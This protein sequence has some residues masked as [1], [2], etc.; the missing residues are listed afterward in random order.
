MSI[1]LGL[2]LSNTFSKIQIE[3]GRCV[4]KQMHIFAD[5]LPKVSDCQKLANVAQFWH[6]DG[7]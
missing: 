7:K 3:E 1:T 4:I 6:E 5:L 2:L